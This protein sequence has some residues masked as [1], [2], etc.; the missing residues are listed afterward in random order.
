MLSRTKTHVRR[1]KSSEK[2]INGQWCPL[3]A[4]CRLKTHRFRH[5]FHCPQYSDLSDK[6][7][8]TCETVP[9][10]VKPLIQTRGAL[11]KELQQCLRSGRA[12][13]RSRT[14]SL[15]GK[16]LGSIPNTIPIS[17]RPPEAADRAIPGHWE[18][19]LIQGSKNS[20]IITLVERHSRFVMLAKIR[21]NKTITVISALIRQARELPAELYKTLTW[22]RGA[23]MTS[24]TRFTIATD[25]QIYFCDP[26]SPWQR[27]SNENTNRLLRQYFPKGTDLSVHSQQRLNSVARQLNE[28]PRK[29]L[30]YES[31]AER[32]NQCVASIG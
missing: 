17:E 28:R 15:K 32:F 30:D 20:Y 19:D 21:D 8:L 7:S 29:T 11:K 13:R 24:H 31:P 4:I 2:S 6:K 27:G 16:G 18:G 12:V 9:L 25:I 3:S 14:S 26:Q 23:E 5:I 22:D 10:S 1:E